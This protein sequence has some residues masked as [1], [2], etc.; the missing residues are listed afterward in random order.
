MPAM[1]TRP[2]GPD[3]RIV[4]DGGMDLFL[5][6]SK[7]GQARGA[8]VIIDVLRAFTTAAYAFEAGARRIWLVESVEEALAV[9]AARPGTLAMGEDRGLRVPG[10]DFSNSPAEVAAAGVRGRDI[11]QRTSAGTFSVVAATGAERRWCASLVCA[12]ATAAAVRSSGLGA[13]T[14][15]ITGNFVDDPDMDG[16]DDLA[17]AELIERARRGEDLDA[18]R[19]S[20]VVASS[21]EARRTLA[22]GH[23]YFHP[24]DIAYATRVD[25]FDFAMEV[26]RIDGRLRLDKTHP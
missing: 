10:F 9:T 17:T 6:R 3:Q 12:S 22:V 24:Q 21:D 25:R 5:P 1:L 4:Q 16:G 11:V 13:P 20:Q 15:V 19:T 14:Y 8:V 7:A 2:S 23:G 26:Q 18:E